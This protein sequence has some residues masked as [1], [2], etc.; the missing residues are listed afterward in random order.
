M[1]GGG[2]AL[3][4]LL[5]DVL[6]PSHCQQL[7]S[8]RLELLHVELKSFE[9]VRLKNLTEHSSRETFF[10]LFSIDSV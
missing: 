1:V 8:D 9:V 3:L 5:V 7:L 4:P 6:E 2:L 10:S